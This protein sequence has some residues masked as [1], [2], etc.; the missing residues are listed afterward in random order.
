MTFADRS[1]AEFLEAVAEGS[2]TPGGGA[3]AAVAGAAGAALE[4]MVCNLTIGTEGYEAAEADLT[5]VR[6]D[7]AARRS[8]L[9]ELADEDAAA[10]EDLL[11]AYRSDADQGRDEAIQEATKRATE[12]PLETA[13]ACLDVLD[14]AVTVTTAGNEN[15][16]SD[17]G[18]GALLAHAAAQAA[19][20]NVRVNLASIE[21]EAFVT[22]TTD[23]A[24]EIEEHAEALL[25][26]VL[27][28][29]DETV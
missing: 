14:H 7:L 27:E 21:D 13:E 5:A 20:Y 8:R 3:V 15:A 2:A 28:R 17:G 19:L 29:V 25:A 16:I 11:A 1:I 24:D 18:T 22:E 9:L 10:F 12:V 26:T 4:E 23:R 6:D